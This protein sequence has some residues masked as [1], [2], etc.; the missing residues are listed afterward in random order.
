MESK[1]LTQKDDHL[2]F[3]KGES[4]FIAKVEEITVYLSNRKTTF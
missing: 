4:K 1:F 3:K 2:A